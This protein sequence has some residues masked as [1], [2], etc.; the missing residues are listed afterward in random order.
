MDKNKSGGDRLQKV[1]IVT[2][3]EYS[4]YHIVG[5]FSSKRN[6]RMIKN[7]ISNECN[8]VNIEVWSVDKWIK[9]LNQHKNVYFVR[10]D[11][12]GNVRRVEKET[13]WYIETEET[14][15]D[16]YREDI[17][18]IYTYVWASTEA[19]AIKI[20]SERRTKYL[21]EKSQERR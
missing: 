10:L 15:K 1:Y 9:G 2:E 3:G 13:A 18:G 11:K 21:I 16:K 7:I 19:E 14:D 6:A 8:M 5:V 20:A 4:G 12:K 17:N